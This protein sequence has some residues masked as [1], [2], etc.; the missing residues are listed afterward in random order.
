LVFIEIC[1]LAL[2]DIDLKM[3]P[4]IKELILQG[5]LALIV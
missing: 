1:R 3:D 4:R 5:E 2:E